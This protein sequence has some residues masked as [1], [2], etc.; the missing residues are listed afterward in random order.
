MILLRDLLF[1]DF[2][3]FGQFM[4]AGEGISTN[5]LT[6]RLARL[7][8]FGLVVKEPDAENATRRVYRLTD[9][10]VSLR[11]VFFAVMEWGI[12]NDR[13]SGVDL[14]FVARMKTAFQK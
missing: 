2:R 14:A 10:G 1:R 5:I 12:A 9:K 8:K 4:N 11:P 7:E 3:Y 13:E 6:N